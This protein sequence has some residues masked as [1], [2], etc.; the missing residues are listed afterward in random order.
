MLE[1]L[2]RMYRVKCKTKITKWTVVSLLFDGVERPVESGA[3]DVVS[4]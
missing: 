4:L 1:D 3:M 2:L